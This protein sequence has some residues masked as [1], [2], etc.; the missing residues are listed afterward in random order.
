ME[1]SM[2]QFYF[3][4][5]VLLVIGAVILLE[6]HIGGKVPLVQAVKGY[7]MDSSTSR[8]V[9]IV[10]T[11]IVGIMKLITPIQPGPAVIGDF[12]PALNLLGLC[13]FYIFESRRLQESPEDVEINIDGEGEKQEESIEKVRSFYYTNK[14]IIGYVT[15]GVAFFHFL[16]P[17]AVLL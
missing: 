15:L 8:V 2:V 9:L 12:F 5:L 7:C 11:A 10:L 16:F 14:R 13:V 3:L 17:G 1:L 4:S 6:E